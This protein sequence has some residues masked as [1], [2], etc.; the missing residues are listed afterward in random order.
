MATNTPIKLYSKE[1]ES[2][3]DASSDSI[4]NVGSVIFDK[5]SKSIFV[6][7]VQYGGSTKEIKYVEYIES[8]RNEGSVTFIGTNLEGAETS[9]ST[10]KLRVIWHHPNL[11]IFEYENV[12]WDD[13]YLY[14]AEPNWLR[15][16]SYSD[17][18]VITISAIETQ[19][20]LWYS[21]DGEDWNQLDTTVQNSIPLNDGDIVAFKGVNSSL[22]TS[23]S[24]LKFNST[25]PIYADG[26]VMS[27]VDGL[28]ITTTIPSSYFFKNLFEGW[29]NLVEPPYLPATTLTE[30]CYWQMFKKSGIEDIPELPATKLASQCYFAMFLDCDELYDLSNI[31]LPATQPTYQCYQQ[32]FDNC[33]YL[34]AGPD[35]K[36]ESIN[37][38]DGTQCMA[39]MFYSCGNLQSVTVNTYD[40]DNGN[41]SNWL[42]GVASSGTV[43][44]NNNANIPSGSASGVPTNWTNQTP[45]V[46]E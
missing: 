33:G 16:Y 44:N 28:G 6:N 29:S 25:A 1:Y 39:K 24:Q 40:W 14:P 12:S 17:N 37:N 41:A 34:I 10:W 35:I 4:T 20:D 21:L 23:S 46:L 7:G 27:L 31:N 8:Y 45:Q 32:M 5:T 36:L 22:N 11:E 42:F 38:N 43:Y 18:N 2:I 30:G 15:F 3:D 9:D 13:R 26:S 19:K